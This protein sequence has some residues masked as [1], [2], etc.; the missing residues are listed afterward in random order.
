MVPGSVPKL[1]GWGQLSG[2]AMM[3]DWSRVVNYLN[4]VMEIWWLYLHKLEESIY[5][6]LHTSVEVEIC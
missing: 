3:S 4:R 6:E 1:C 2:S 5:Q